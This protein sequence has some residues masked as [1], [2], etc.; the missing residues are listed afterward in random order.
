[1]EIALGRWS[2]PP[3]LPLSLHPLGAWERAQG[4]LS[5]TIYFFLVVQHMSTGAG[6]GGKGR[7][8]RKYFPIE[9]S[10]LVSYVQKR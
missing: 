8:S 5:P 2:R 6:G 10:F 3:L 4:L 9:H 7:P 1:M